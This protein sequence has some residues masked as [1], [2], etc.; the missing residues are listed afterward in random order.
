LDANRQLVAASIPEG[1]FLA[2]PV[3]GQLRRTGQQ[4]LFG[5]G[6]PIETLFRRHL[7]TIVTGVTLVLTRSQ[8]VFSQE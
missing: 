5:C 2:P 3:V 1:V 6:D 8:L 7:T 4:V